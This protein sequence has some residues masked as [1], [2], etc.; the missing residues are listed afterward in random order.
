MGYELEMQKDMVALLKLFAGKVPDPESHSWVLELARN[1]RQWPKGHELFD[2]VRERYL[3][4]IDAGAQADD[5]IREAQ[6]CFEEVCLQSLYNESH[7]RDPFDPLTPY[8]IL[9]NALVLAR[10]MGLESGLVIEAV[11]P[12]KAFEPE[13]PSGD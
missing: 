5:R 13:E 10:E 3:G 1:R 9:K 6:Y 4:A 2:R 12:E 8:W 7:P 11:L